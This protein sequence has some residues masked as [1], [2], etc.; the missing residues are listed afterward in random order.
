MENNLKTAN[1]IVSQEESLKGTKPAVNK[2]SWKRV[3][4]IVLVVILLILVATGVYFFVT[5]RP[6]KIVWASLI[7]DRR[8]NYLQCHD[9]PF[10]QQAQKTFY[11]HSDFV[12]KVKN[13]P[14]VKDFFIE[15]IVCPA[16]ESQ[17][18][19]IKGQGELV[20]QNR[21]ARTQAEKILGNTFFGVPYDG[22]QK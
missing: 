14:G 10:F 13:V 18:T 16:Y 5:W 6:V 15:K 2:F 8:E 17:M 3:G 20:Y 22:Y 12:A 7:F 21:H 1:E 11:Q 19:F 9:L 4:K